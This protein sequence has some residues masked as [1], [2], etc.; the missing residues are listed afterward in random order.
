ME[1]SETVSVVKCCDTKVEKRFSGLK[2]YIFTVTGSD[3]E[4]MQLP[5]PGP[6]PAP[7]VPGRLRTLRRTH[8]VGHFFFSISFNSRCRASTPSL[9]NSRETVGVM[10]EIPMKYHF[11]GFHTSC[12][13]SLTSAKKV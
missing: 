6:G 4:I 3:I 2:G 10:Y 5:V 12:Q 9:P 1:A 8:R 7:S 13:Q 11:S